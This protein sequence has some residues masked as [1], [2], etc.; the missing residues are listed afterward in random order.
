MKGKKYSQG[1]SCETR[2]NVMAAA[3]ERKFGGRANIDG[4]A[5]KRAHKSRDIGALPDG[6]PASKHAGRSSRKG[7]HGKPLLSAASGQGQNPAGHSSSVEGIPTR[8]K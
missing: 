5:N 6:P 2:A 4:G 7:V 8:K 1:G 3:K